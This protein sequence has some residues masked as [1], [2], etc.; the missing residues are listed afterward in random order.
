MELGEYLKDIVRPMLSATEVKLLDVAPKYKARALVTNASG[1]LRVRDNITTKQV[2]VLRREEPALTS[3]EG[4]LVEKL[5]QS[6]LEV[7]QQAQAFVPELID[8]IISKAIADS[9]A[10]GSEQK[11]TMEKVLRIFQDWSTQTYEGARIS[12]GVKVGTAP[13]EFLKAPHFCEIANED[14]AKALTDGVESWWELTSD[15]MVQGFHGSL[16]KMPEVLSQ[17]GFYPIK[18]RSMALGANQGAAT[19]A[20]NRNGEIL[21]FSNSE[22][23]FAKRR[24]GWVHFAHDAIIRQMSS[25]R[26]RDRPLRSA[27]YR[28]CLDASFSRTGACIGLLKQDQIKPFME[29]KVLQPED[30]QHADASLSLK[31]RTCAVLIRGQ[32]FSE[33]DRDTRKEMLALDGA[34]VVLPKGTVLASG[35]IINLGRLPRGNQGGRSAAAKTL[36]LYGLGIKVSQDGKISGYKEHH[37]DDPWFQVG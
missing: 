12:A 30:Q 34:T 1:T 28:S 22:L 7:K 3:A 9:V 14:F 15:G 31:A 18:Y 10:Q 36:G 20:L 23:R 16:S 17:D 35:A 32:I 2:W 13:D 8:L 29:M 33:I 6:F 26:K 21:V 24:G 37:I 4:D 5:V 25:G 27:I 11:N 19:A